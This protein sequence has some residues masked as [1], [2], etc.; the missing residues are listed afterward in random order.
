M[1]KEAR[2]YFKLEKLSMRHTYYAYFDAKDYMADSLFIKHKVTVEFQQEFC[3]DRTPYCVIVCRIRKKDEAAFLDALRELPAKMLLC[4]YL[5]YAA[6]CEH[7]MNKIGGVPDETNCTVEKAE[8][9][10][11]KGI[12]CKK[13][14]QLE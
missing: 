4:G 3:K 1:P 8:Q 2:H 9:A 10:G 14:Q 11:A 12:S 7:F 6:Q 5:N 13:A